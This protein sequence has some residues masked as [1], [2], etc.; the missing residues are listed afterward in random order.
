M[1]P[2]RHSNFHNYTLFKPYNDK[3]VKRYM[4]DIT[5]DEPEVYGNTEWISIK[6]HGQ[7][8]ML[9]QIVSLR[10][11]RWGRLT[12]QELGFSARWSVSPFS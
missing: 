5:V 6:I 2:S 8:F 9:H 10:A 4:I 3:S 1:D 11:K 12:E 7:S